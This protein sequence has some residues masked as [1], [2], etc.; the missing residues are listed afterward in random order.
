MDLTESPGA[1]VR[2]TE[3]R[4]GSSGNL[5]WVVDGATDFTQ[6]RTLPGDSNVQWLVNLVDQRLREIGRTNEFT[7]VRTVLEGLGE[8][9]RRRLAEVAPAGLRNHPCCSIGVA[10]LLPDRLELG[11][12]G[13][14]TLI[15]YR[16]SQ[17][18]CEVSTAFFDRREAD[19]VERSRTER[20]SRQEIIG[21]MFARRLEYI[22]GAHSES[23]FSGHREA[24]LKIHSAILSLDRVD[25]VLLCTDGFARAIADYALFPDWQGLRR[26]ADEKGLDEIT[27]RI[28]RHESHPDSATQTPKFKNADDLAAVLV[29]TERET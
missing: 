13:D 3:D 4:V 5:A 11:R 8:E 18:V 23:V 9:V 29:S 1:G 27:S 14:A 6:E 16:R 2:P 15:A 20:Q 19:A 28:R 7:G 22:K 12:I 10:V 24:V 17:V 26:C 25:S 21:E